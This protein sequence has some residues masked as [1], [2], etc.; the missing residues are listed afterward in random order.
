[1]TSSITPVRPSSTNTNSL[2][3]LSSTPTSTP[4][5]LRHS[6]FN[7]T[8]LCNLNVACSSH[9]LNP[10]CDLDRTTP[11]LTPVGG[12]GQSYSSGSGQSSLLTPANLSESDCFDMTSSS[13]ENMTSRHEHDTC[14][15]QNP[16]TTNIPFLS[17]TNTNYS[18]AA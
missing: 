5:S 2:A 8:S 4:N 12:L 9:S 7:L 17:P 11:D 18:V 10:H 14:K 6:E 15:H 16:N 1:M 13:H 3:H